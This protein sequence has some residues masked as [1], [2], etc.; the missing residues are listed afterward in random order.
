MTVSRFALLTLL[1]ASPVMAADLP[2]QGTSMS[3]VEQQFGSPVQKL[4]PVG[5]PAITR[6]IYPDYVVYFERKSVIHSVPSGKQASTQD[7]A[8]KP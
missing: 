3:T 2:A 4:A 8:A 6:W 5:K 1:A 7:S